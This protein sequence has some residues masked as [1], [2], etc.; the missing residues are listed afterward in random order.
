MWMDK[1]TFSY[2]YTYT[3]NKMAI[4]P[5]SITTANISPAVNAIPELPLGLNPTTC[6]RWRLNESLTRSLSLRVVV[7]SHI[8]AKK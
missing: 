8:L 6:E 3:F 4:R 7:L 5:L 2:T 1:T